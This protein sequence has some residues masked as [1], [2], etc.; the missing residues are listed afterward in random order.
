MNY[1][2]ELK[3]KPSTKEIQRE[4]VRV[5]L[6]MKDDDDVK[7][8]KNV[9]VKTTSNIPIITEDIDVNYNRDALKQKILANKLSKITAKTNVAE[10]LPISRPTTIVIEPK[11][12]DAT[13][14]TE[15]KVPPPAKLKKKILLEIE[16]DKKEL[17]ISLHGL[18]EMC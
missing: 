7:P 12:V 4:I 18:P 5:N 2:E 9:S 1:L 8:S 17:E 15:K 14:I 3:N 16:Q 6:G 11:V 10:S 13:E